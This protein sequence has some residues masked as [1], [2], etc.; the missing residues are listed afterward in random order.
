[1]VVSAA[2]GATRY[3][4]SSTTSVESA[5][6]GFAAAAPPGPFADGGPNSV[7]TSPSRP[8]RVLKRWRLLVIW[9]TTAATVPSGENSMSLAVF[10]A[11]TSSFPTTWPSAPSSS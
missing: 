8:R 1:M 4:A 9:S 11:S 5:V 3:G 7:V 6:H 10:A 2:C